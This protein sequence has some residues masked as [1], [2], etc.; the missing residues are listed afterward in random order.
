[1]YLHI[2]SNLSK[3]VTQRTEKYT[4]AGVHYIQV[5]VLYS[6]DIATFLIDNLTF[7]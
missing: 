4:W 7:I 3:K 2:Q 5:K 1:M 6:W